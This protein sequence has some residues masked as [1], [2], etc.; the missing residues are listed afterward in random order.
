[1][2]YGPNFTRG[3]LNCG[4]H[5]HYVRRLVNVYISV[6]YLKHTS[7]TMQR[8]TLTLTLIVT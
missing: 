5:R 8:P 7:S 1:M 4:D 2:T 6:P 3:M